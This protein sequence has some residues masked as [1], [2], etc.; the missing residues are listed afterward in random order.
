MMKTLLAVFAFALLI[1]ASPVFAQT[2]AAAFAVTG[3]ST[4]Q[5]VRFVS[6]ASV[7]RTRV[8][9]LSVSGEALFDVTS[10]GNVFDWTLQ[11]GDGQRVADGDYICVVTVKTLS[12]KI[13]QRIGTVSLASGKAVLLARADL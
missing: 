4:G 9:I 1:C 6:P 8:E 13:S 7:V 10:K 5:Q 12:G 3:A 2:N 11:G